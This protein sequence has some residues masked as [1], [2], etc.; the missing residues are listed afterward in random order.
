[1]F[2]VNGQHDA[3]F[4]TA[5]EQMAINVLWNFSNRVFSTYEMML[6]PQRKTVYTP[7][8]TYQGL[9]PISSYPMYG[10]GWMPFLFNGQWFNLECGSCGP[11]CGCGPGQQW[12]LKLPGPVDVVTDVEINGTVLEPTDYWLNGDNLNRTDDYWPD[13]QEMRYPLGAVGHS[14]W[15]ITYTRGVPVPGGG[16][17]SAGVLAVEL[18]KTMIHDKT[19]LIP[20]RV[21]T[22]TRNS[23]TSMI[24]DVFTQL[25]KQRTGVSFVDNWLASVTQPVRHAASVRSVDVA[26]SNGR[27]SA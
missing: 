4:Q 9:G 24:V 3:D 10:R 26:R 27:W 25:D 11:D 21:Q 8:S 14:T 2:T 16:Q 15:G 22:A 17:L 19:S 6:R 18:G 23:S 20:T 7:P 13:E 12:S 1:V 5:M